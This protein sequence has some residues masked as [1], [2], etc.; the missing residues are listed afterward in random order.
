AAKCILDF[1]ARSEPGD[2]ERHALWRVYFERHDRITTWDMVDRAA[3]RVVGGWFVGRNKQHL[4]DLAV[5][6]CPLRRRTAIT[7]PL[8]FLQSGDDD[9]VAAGTA[10][11]RR[12]VRALEPIVHNAVGVFLDKLGSRN[13]D[14]LF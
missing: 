3:P 10:I 13:Q 1:K 6:A 14:Q 7:A 4:I 2:D 8:Y 5:S 12:L 9:D 11:A